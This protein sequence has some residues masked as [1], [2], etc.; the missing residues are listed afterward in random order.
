MTNEKEEAAVPKEVNPKAKK[1]V[2]KEPVMYVGPTVNGIGIQNRVYTEIPKETQVLFQEVPEL[3]NL[4][5]PVRQYPAACRM[6]RERK[7]Y[8]YSAFV[9]A[10]DFKNG[11]K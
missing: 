1:I 3:K 2:K 7:G 4:F 8:I 11:G 5:I 10:L 6:I 9:R